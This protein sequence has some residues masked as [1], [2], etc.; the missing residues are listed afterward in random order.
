MSLTAM[1]IQLCH[2]YWWFAWPTSWFFALWIIVAYPFFI[3]IR[4][5]KLFLLCLWSNN[6]QVILR[7]STSLSFNS[8][9]IQFPCFWIIPMAFKRLKI[10]DR[11]TF[12]DSASSSCV[13]LGS[14]WVKLPLPHLQT[15]LKMVWMFLVFHQNH[16]FHSIEINTHMLKSIKYNH[17]KWQLSTA[18]C[19]SAALFFKWKQKLPANCILFGTKFDIFNAQKNNVYTLTK[20]Y[21]KLKS[22]NGAL[23]MKVTTIWPD[24]I[25]L[26]TPFHENPLKLVHT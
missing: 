24:A 10:V 26:V 20:W 4:C 13:W 3:T 9:G 12:N 11:L 16:L 1:N 25:V 18:C 21:W 23:N 2:R 22:H 19:F 17:Y 6:S 14:W 8:Y 15:F 7:L 5:K